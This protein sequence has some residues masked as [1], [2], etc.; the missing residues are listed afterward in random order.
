MPLPLVAAGVGERYLLV[1]RR[2]HPRFKLRQAPHL[3]LQGRDLAFQAGR[4]GRARQRWFL[5]V[6]AV[7]LLQIARDA[8]LDLLLAALHLRPREV[9]VPG[10]DRL[11]LG[12]VDRNAGGGEQLKF[13]TQRHAPGAHLADRFAI[14]LAEGGDRLVIGNQAAR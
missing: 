12:A 14:V 1:R 11:E 8:L 6:G 4:L 10:V 7:H 2:E 9:P 13:A 5:S 3:L